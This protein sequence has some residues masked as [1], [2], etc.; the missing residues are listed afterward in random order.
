MESLGFP[1]SVLDIFDEV[2]DKLLVLNSLL[3]D[4]LS[5]HAPLKSIRTK[6][7][8]APWI[9]KS[10]HDEMDRRNKLLQRF[11]SM[12]SNSD[13]KNFTAQHNRVVTLQR[14][15]KKQ[16]FHSLISRNS[17]PAVLWKTLRSVVPSSAASPATPCLS[18]HEVMSLANSLNSYFVTVSSPSDDPMLFSP[19]SNNPL[20]ASFSLKPVSTQWCEEALRNL[21]TP[22]LFWFGWYTIGS[23]TSCFFF[24]QWAS[25]SY[26]E[27]ISCVLHFST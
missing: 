2:D 21:K 9:S 20:P 12:K 16:Y 14:Q 13:W 6:K 26:L 18:E 11:R 27:L 23:S 19:P 17:N 3:N 4:V 1:W 8:P 7:H 25:L 10:V 22:S 5:L 24:S 15:A